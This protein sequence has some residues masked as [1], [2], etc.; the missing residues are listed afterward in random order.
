VSAP[1]TRRDRIAR[2]VAL[3]FAANAVA[4]KI[5]AVGPVPMPMDLAARLR[6]LTE[7]AREVV[8]LTEREIAFLENARDWSEG[9]A[10]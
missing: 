8:T 10:R 3:G 2:Y 4:E 1:L 9:D 5:A 7:A 6:V